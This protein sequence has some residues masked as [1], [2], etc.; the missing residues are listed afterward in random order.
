MLLKTYANLI[1]VEKILLKVFS[2]QIRP[3]R[4]FR[5]KKN[6]S[7]IFFMKNPSALSII[8]LYYNNQRLDCYN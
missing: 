8:N 7:Y 4:K 2:Y 6:L 3:C 5:I 1:R